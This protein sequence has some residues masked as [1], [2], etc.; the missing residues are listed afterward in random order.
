MFACIL[1]AQAKQASA[2][3]AEGFERVLIGRVDAGLF[4][5]G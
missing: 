2:G 3:A 5:G 4:W 1:T